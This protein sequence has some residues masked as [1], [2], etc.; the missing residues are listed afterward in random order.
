M[1]QINCQI[2]DTVLIVEY[3]IN[4]GRLLCTS[5]IEFRG[6]K[7]EHRIKSRG[8][9]DYGWDWILKDFIENYSLW[10]C[11]SWQETMI[12]AYQIIETA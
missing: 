4:E 1:Q 7:I 5:D 9:N 3:E 6:W 10:N 11:G 12:P 2:G 8:Y